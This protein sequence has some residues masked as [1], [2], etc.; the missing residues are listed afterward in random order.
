MISTLER[1]TYNL[2]PYDLPPNLAFTHYSHITS[3]HPPKTY[4]VYGMDCWKPNTK[5]DEDV[6]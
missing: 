3:A 6:M 5:Q 1:S 4:D 2:L